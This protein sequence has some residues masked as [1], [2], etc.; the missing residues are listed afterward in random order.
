[1]ASDFDLDS[2]LKN[3]KCTRL[4]D[5]KSDTFGICYMSTVDLALFLAIALGQLNSCGFA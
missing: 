5:P 3:G 1:M 4:I 2:S